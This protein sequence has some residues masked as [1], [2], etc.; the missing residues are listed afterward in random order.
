MDARAVK[1]KRTGPCDNCCERESTQWR[2]GPPHAPTLCNACGVHWGRKK[3]LPQRGPPQ[4]AGRAKRE[5][6]ARAVEPP[7][8]ESASDSYDDSEAA[9]MLIVL[10]SMPAARAAKRRQV[11]ARER[12][13]GDGLSSGT[14]STLRGPKSV[15]SRAAASSGSE[16]GSLGGRSADEHAPAESDSA[17]THASAQA[18]FAPAAAAGAAC[19]GGKV[20]QAAHKGNARMHAG[21]AKL[22]T[23]ARAVDIKSKAA[24]DSM[25]YSL[26]VVLTA[27]TL[28]GGPVWPIAGFMPV[29]PPSAFDMFRADWQAVNPAAGWSDARRMWETLPAD[30]TNAYQLSAARAV[31]GLFG[32]SLL[33]ACVPV[34]LPVVPAGAPLVAGPTACTPL[35]APACLAN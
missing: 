7:A 25:E 29:A 23:A 20:T 32:A 35:Q 15:A 8:L 5:R 14:G 31:P 28:E 26:P 30:V 12:F 2:L 9:E 33:Q 24:V 19:F 3:K 27:A 10:S 21:S 34:A 13:S 18:A 16:D 11:G 4:A 17:L 22:D 1:K 6:E